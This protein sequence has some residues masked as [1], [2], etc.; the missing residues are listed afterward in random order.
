MTSRETID[1][2]C[3]PGETEAT[4]RVNLRIYG[5][6]QGV[7]FRANTR[8]HARSLGLH[9]WVRNCPDGSVE[10][11]AEGPEDKVRSLELWCH[12]GSPASRVDQVKATYVD[13]TFDLPPFTVRY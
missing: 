4:A 2:D 3:W 12:Q 13:P 1:R 5:R 10:A 6:V 11:T 8:D 9:G 7:Y